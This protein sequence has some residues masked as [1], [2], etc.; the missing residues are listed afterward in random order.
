MTDG[1][2][3]ESFVKKVLL[4]KD[5]ILCLVKSDKGKIFGG[6]MSF[7]EGLKSSRDSKACVFSLTNK[8]QLKVIDSDKAILVDHDGLFFGATQP[9]D[10]RLNIRQ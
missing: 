9:R 6:F 4:G 3:K 2:K 1:L 8:M 5:P 10:L 7:N